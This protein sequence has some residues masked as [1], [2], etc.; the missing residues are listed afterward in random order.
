MQGWIKLHRK[1]RDNPIF[2]D[3]KFFRLWIICLTEATH[4]ERDQVVDRQMVHLLPGQFVTGRFTLFDMYNNGLKQGDRVKEPK[5][6]YRWLE[7]LEKLGYLTINKTTKYSVVTINNWSR[8]QEVD[9][10]MTNKRP[11]NEP[12]VDHKQEYKE[13]KNEKK[14]HI[15]SQ[16]ENL[17][18]RYSN[19][20]LKII[21]DYLEMIRHTRSSGKISDSVILKMY[22][23]WDK[24]PEKRVEYGVKTHLENSAFHSKK[25]NYTLGIIRNI[26]VDEAISKLNQKLEA[27]VNK[28]PRSKDIEFQRWIAAGGDPESFNWS[29]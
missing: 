14:T 15:P 16:I 9:Q 26:K 10:Q 25:E 12:T 19:S 2:N 17:R 8:Y 21:D 24:Y 13:V 1:I 18:H 28:D 27:T 29:D 23:D 22:Q 11:S 4:K 3:H 20:Q 6:V 5:T 7:R